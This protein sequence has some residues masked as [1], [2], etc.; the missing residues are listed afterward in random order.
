MRRLIIPLTLLLA[1]CSADQ[2]WYTGIVEG[3]QYLLSSPIAERLVALEVHEGDQVETDQILARLD[4]AALDLKIAALQAQLE[5]LTYQAEE[6]EARI[7]QA[8]EMRDY[9]RT[10]YERNKTLLEAQ[11]VSPQTVDELASRLSN[12]EAELAA[13]Q[14]RRKAL[15][16]QRKALRAELEGLQLQRTRTLITAPS[17]GIVEEVFYDVG[18]MV[19][20]FSPV[21]EVADLA[22]VSTTVYVEE[23]TLALIRPGDEVRVRTALDERTGTVVKLPTRAEFSPKE[24]RTPETREA[25]VYAVKVAIPNE[26]LVLKIGMPVEVSFQ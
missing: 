6:L 9:L 21:V 10:T 2:H 11:A 17:S 13:L 18:E 4:Q 12:Q 23:R 24:V 8:Q 1:A 14:A 5:Q 3:T 15:G 7:R 20:A 22:H 16:A 25:L 19:P 26:D